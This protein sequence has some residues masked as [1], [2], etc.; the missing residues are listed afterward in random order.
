MYCSYLWLLLTFVVGHGICVPDDQLEM[1]QWEQM[2]GDGT[3]DSDWAQGEKQTW[4]AMVPDPGNGQD[5]T[6]AGLKDIVQ[7]QFNYVYAQEGQRNAQACMVAAFYESNSRTVYSSTVPYGGRKR[8]MQLTAAR[9]AP[10]WYNQVRNMQPSHPPWHAEDGAYY[11]YEVST[12]EK[13]TGNSYPQGSMVAAYGFR[14]PGDGIGPHPLCGAAP[15]RSP[16]CQ[17]V[18]RG[19]GVAQTQPRQPPPPAP[20]PDPDP[21]DSEDQVDM[22]DGLSD[23]ELTALLDQI[24]PAPGL[25][26]QNLP[27]KQKR[28]S[29]RGHGLEKRGVNSSCV[30]AIVQSS[31][32]VEKLSI[33][34]PA[35]DLTSG[36][37]P[38]T[39]SPTMTSPTGPPTAIVPATTLTPTCYQQNQDPDQ[40]ILQQGCI[41]NQGA[42]TETLPLLATNVPYSSSCAYTA[43]SPSGTIAITANFGPAVTNTMICSVCSQIADYGNTCKPLANCLPQ[44]PTATIQIGSS[45][46]PVGTLTS[47][48]LSSSISSA[49]ASLCPP[50][51]QTTTSTTCDETAKVKIPNIVYVDEGSLATDGEL[52][53]QI[54]SSGYNDTALLGPLAGMAALSIASSATGGNCYQAEYTI[55]EKKRKRDHPY[56]ITEKIELCHAGH[57]ASPQIYSQWYVRILVI[58]SLFCQC[59]KTICC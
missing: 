52:I 37:S 12:D 35:S 29:I 13:P 19:L 45:P 43:L 5:L 1:V 47:S 41:C 30:S 7:K 24:C 31:V 28:W 36:S 39:T 4:S 3:R 40:G 6:Y 42:V 53:V 9:D 57:F 27:S 46:V 8:V 26:A 44:T 23:S 58:H 18:A 34:L 49:I 38:I 21:N 56:P 54:D 50:V 16:S 22:D 10:V 32:P 11:T 25:G 59:S 55:E 20:V 51:T 14:F 2:L 48:L 17:V 15:I 33:T